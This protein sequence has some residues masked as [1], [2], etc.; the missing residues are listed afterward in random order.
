M[1]VYIKGWNI[2]GTVYANKDD[3]KLPL[4]GGTMTGKITAQAGV[5]TD[6]GTSGGLDMNNS[7]IVGVNAI[8]TKDAADNAAEGINFYRD[9]THVDTLWM[10]NGSILFVP[11]R[12]LGTSTTAANSQKV[13]RF[14]TAPTSGSVVVADGTTGG[15]KTKALTTSDITSGLGG[16]QIRPNYV[17]QGSVPTSLSDGQVCFVYE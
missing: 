15:V 17:I 7:N 8:Y 12:T 14:T 4:S 5:Y 1:P 16:I 3:T 2:N 13:A 6:D 11:N 9:A 10:Q